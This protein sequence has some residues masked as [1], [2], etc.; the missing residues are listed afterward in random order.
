M[1]SH[2]LH[3]LAKSIGTHSNVPPC[4]ISGT[5]GRETG[6]LKEINK[7]LVEEV[8]GTVSIDI[9]MFTLV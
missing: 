5:G 4:A 9:T 2:V 8:G 3:C 7:I 6:P 1:Y